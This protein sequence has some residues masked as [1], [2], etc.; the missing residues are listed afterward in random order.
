MPHIY[1]LASR[2]LPQLLKDDPMIVVDA[3]ASGAGEYT[4]WNSLFPNVRVH[5]FEPDEDETRRMAANAQHHADHVEYSTTCLGRDE[6][7]RP[8]YVLKERFNASFY[9]IDMEH[10][11]RKKAYRDGKPIRQTETFALDHISHVDSVSLDTYFKDKGKYPDYI[12][13]DI[14]GAEL[15]LMQASPLSVACAVAI[16]VDVIFHADWIGAPVFADID[17]YM[18]QNGFALYDFRSMKRN[19]QFDSP[20]E[21]YDEFGRREGQAACGDA[22]YIRDFQTAKQPRPPFKTLLKTAVAAEVNRS[23]DYAFELVKIAMDNAPDAETRRALERIITEATADHFTRQA[24]F[25]GHRRLKNLEKIV[26]AVLPASAITP[27]KPVARAIR[28]MFS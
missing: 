15:E 22:I 2:I 1:P 11:H 19:F 7:N 25:A 4:R 20:T 23:T 16:S 9:E 12:K 17:A 13:L 28:R 26:T 8:L 10:Y 27:L 18:R 6:K 21:F 24:E 5:A 14:E 3:G